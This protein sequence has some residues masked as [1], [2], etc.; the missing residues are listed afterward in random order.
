[1]IN[2]LNKVKTSCPCDKPSNSPNFLLTSITPELF[3]DLQLPPAQEK[4]KEESLKST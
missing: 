1:M 3:V 4:Y 2:K